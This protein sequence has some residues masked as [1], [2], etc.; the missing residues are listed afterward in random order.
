VAPR[1]GGASGEGRGGGRRWRGGRRGAGAPLAPRVQ[2]ARCALHPAR[3][4]GA[5][6]GDDPA[7]LRARAAL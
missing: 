3:S 7:G 1:P 6:H 4:A 2:P 5:A